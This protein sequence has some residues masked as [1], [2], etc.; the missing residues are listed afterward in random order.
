MRAARTEQHGCL[1]NAPGPAAAERGGASHGNKG[2]VVPHHWRR[3]RKGRGRICKAG[4]RRSARWR[5]GGTERSRRRGG[6]H[7]QIMPAPGGVAGMQI[8]AGPFP[9]PWPPGPSRQFKRRR[10]C[11]E[12]RKRDLVCYTTA[13]RSSRPAPPGAPL[14]AAPPAPPGRPRLRHERGPAAQ[15]FPGERPVPARGARSRGTPPRCP[16]PPRARSALAASPPPGTPGGDRALRPPPHVW[17]E[18]VSPGVPPRRDGGR[19]ERGPACEPLAGRRR[20][21]G[22]CRAAPARCPFGGARQGPP[23]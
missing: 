15:R 3:A 8:L 16:H 18:P 13:L 2:R 17:A 9:A 20:A 10:A 7:M 19:W 14:P 5:G 23:P 12:R 4:S 22:G 11:A 1:H 21:G 6:A